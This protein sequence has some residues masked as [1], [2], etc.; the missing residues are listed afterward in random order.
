MNEYEA[1]SVIIECCRRLYDRGFFPG[2]DGNVS[3]RV[4]G[5]RV[6]ITPTGVCKDML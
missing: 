3:L 1:R 2:V 5:G 4:D 6:L